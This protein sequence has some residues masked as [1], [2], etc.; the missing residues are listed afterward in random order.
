MRASR[1][2]WA[3]PAGLAAAVSDP[4]ELLAFYAQRSPIFMAASFDASAAADRGQQIGD[5]T[6]VHLTIPTPNPWVPLRILGLGKGATERIEADVYLLTD[7]R[8]ALL[9][10]AFERDGTFLTHDAAATDLLLDDLRSDKGMEWVPSSGWL[11]KLTIDAEAGDLTYDL[12]VDAS[13]QGT[14]SR[15]AAG[16]AVAD[17]PARS[18]PSPLGIAA[19][20]LISAVA[21]AVGATRSAVGLP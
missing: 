6:P 7:R 11:T 4:P 18:D 10:D 3:E 9:P 5:G 13:G 19:G 12:A 20:L 15:V 8:P 14:P 21:A 2:T 1:M 17:A 16:L